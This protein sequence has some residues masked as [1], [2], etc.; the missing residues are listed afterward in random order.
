MNGGQTTNKTSKTNYLGM[1]DFKVIDINENLPHKV[2]EVICVHCGW[3]WIAVRPATTLLKHLE[4]PD[5]G[6]QGKVIE[7][8]ESLNE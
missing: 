3:R 4:C 8:G 5:C 6:N 1:S 2:S 7:T